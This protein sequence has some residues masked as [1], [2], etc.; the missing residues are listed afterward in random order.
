M[1]FSEVT[2]WLSLINKTKEGNNSVPG[3]LEKKNFKKMIL[4]WQK[5]FVSQHEIVALRLMENVQFWILFWTQQSHDG[6]RAFS[7]RKLPGK[8]KMSHGSQVAVYCIKLFTQMLPDIRTF[9]KMNRAL[10]SSSPHFLPA[11]SPF[12]FQ[13][14]KRGIFYISCQRSVNISKYC[15]SPSVGITSYVGL[16]KD[17]FL[18]VGKRVV[19]PLRRWSWCTCT[20]GPLSS[21][22]LTFW[23]H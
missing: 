23:S 14:R 8:K 12:S 3:A 9:T 21:L 10:C 20:F 6:C 18:S 4:C 19:L 7:R 17:K 11:F 16:E 22:Q 15:I 5:I 2:S 1:C 13:V